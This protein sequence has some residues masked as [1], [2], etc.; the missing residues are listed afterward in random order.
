MSNYLRLLDF[1]L[2]TDKEPDVSRIICMVTLVDSKFNNVEKN[3]GFDFRICGIKMTAVA[4]TFRKNKNIL[5]ICS[6]DRV[7]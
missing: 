3:N 7:F 6:K 5:K 1:F 4:G 2:D